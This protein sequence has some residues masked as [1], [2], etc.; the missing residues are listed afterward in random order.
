MSLRFLRTAPGILSIS[1]LVTL[2]I[3]L[4]ST[5]ASPQAPVA[6]LSQKA[7]TAEEAAIFDRILNRVRFENDGTEVSETEAVVRI[8]SQAGVEEL[9]TTGNG[10]SQSLPCSPETRWNIAPSPA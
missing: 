9:A 6:P 1:S 3:V 5:D 2:Q 4:M 10:I 7:N 8:Q